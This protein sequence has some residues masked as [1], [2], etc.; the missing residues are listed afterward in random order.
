LLQSLTTWVWWPRTH[1][2]EGELTPSSCPLTSTCCSTHI[3]THTHTHTHTLTH[4]RGV[5]LKLSGMPGSW[6][7]LVQFRVW[8]PWEHTRDLA[9]WNYKPALWKPSSSCSVPSEQICESC[10]RSLPPSMWAAVQCAH[11]LFPTLEPYRS[12]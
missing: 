11:L 9:C 8:L 5:S 4:S 1:T 10:A 12:N 6:L 7:S 3:H 2:G